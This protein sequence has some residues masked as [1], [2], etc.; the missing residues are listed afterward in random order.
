MN[1]STFT[2]L[3][4]T[5][6]KEIQE[7]LDK[8]YSKRAIARMLGRSPNTISQE[9]KRNTVAGAYIAEKAQHKAY[10]RHKY[11]RY[12]SKKIVAHTA[13]RD[14]VETQLR[15]GKSPESIAGRLK[16]GLEYDPETKEQ[17]PSVS[18]DTIEAY[19]ASPYGR[20]LEY[21]IA[22]LKKAQGRKRK[23]QAP[24]TA[25]VVRG[26]PK[27]SIHDRPAEIDARERV[28]DMEIDFIVSGRAGVGYLLT[29][30][31]RKVRVGYIRKVYPVSVENTRAALQSIQEKHPTIRSFTT[32][33]DI[34]WAYHRA[35]EE[36][37][38]APFYFCDPYSS[39]Q[40]GSVENYNREVRKYIPKGADISQYTEEY[41]QEV[42]DTLNDRFMSELGYLT[43]LEALELAQEEATRREGATDTEGRKS[44]KSTENSKKN[45]KNKSKKIAR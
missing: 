36:V 10:A 42:E 18:R 24:G 1:D 37:L 39:W 32:D 34:L 7:L 11:T 4:N 20:V 2:Q 45:K 27:K 9:V 13:L 8:G 16:A 19:I 31:D 38:E 40:K 21:D 22:Q 35:L 3:S 33:N 28:G 12:Q 15:R 44:K 25:K 23:R 17:L 26:D 41:I 14:F 29:A 6:R 5:E 43:P 30:V